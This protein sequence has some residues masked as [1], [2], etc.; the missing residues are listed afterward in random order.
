MQLWWQGPCP[1]FPLLHGGPRVV[2][3]CQSHGMPSILLH[4][5]LPSTDFRRSAK[6]FKEMGILKTAFVVSVLEAGWDLLMSDTDTV[7]MRDPSNFL[8]A[9]SP[10]G[11]ADMMVTSDSVSRKNDVAR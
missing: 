3:F 7:W 9:S 8:A 10:L 6:T 5:N 4:S 2:Q 11:V 1:L